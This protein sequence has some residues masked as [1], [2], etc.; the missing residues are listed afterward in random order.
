MSFP[1]SPNDGDLYTSGSGTTYQYSDT[2]NAWEIVLQAVTGNQGIQG[3]TGV[4][5]IQGSTGVIGPQGDQ[6]A[7]GAVG[8]K[9]DQGETGEQGIQ[10][11]TGAVGTQGSQGSQGVTG[12]R[13]VTGLDLSLYNAGDFNGSGAT[14]N[15]T[16]GYSQY[17]AMKAG[18]ESGLLF[19]SGGTAGQKCTLRLDYN[20][21]QRPAGSTGIKWANGTFPIMS[22]YTGVNDIITVFYDGTNYFAQASMGFKF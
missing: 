22:G 16:N 5:G 17:V 6:G 15:L 12:L 2:R 13:G 1:L 10:G 7:T 20:V 11:N 18:T 21:N 3:D 4:Q 8:D 19:L 14:L 9:G